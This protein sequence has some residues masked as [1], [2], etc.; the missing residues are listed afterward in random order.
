MQDYNND[1]RLPIP[2]LWEMLE[3][4][5]SL[6]HE[7]VR[8]VTVCNKRRVIIDV[9]ANDLY[10]SPRILEQYRF[11]LQVAEEVE[12][13]GCT[14]EDFHD[15]LA[16]PLLP[17]FQKLGTI[18]KKAETLDTFFNP[19]IFRYSLRAEGDSLVASEKEEDQ[20]EIPMFGSRIREEDYAKFPVFEPSQLHACAR[21]NGFGPP[22]IKPSKTQLPDGSVAF[23]KV[24][25]PGD[26]HSLETELRSYNKIQDAHL[27]PTL[28]ISRLLGIVRN[29]TLIV[30]ILLTYIDCK[31]KTLSCAAKSSSEASLRA[32]WL[33]QIE[34]TVACLHRSGIAW[35][36]AKPDN[37]MIDQNQD[38]WL[39]DFGD[40]YTEG[41]VPKELAGTIEGDRVG[42]EKIACFLE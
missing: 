28:R 14:I 7:D 1:P 38:A 16:E 11:F 8:L 30:G 23:L 2:P 34:E 33:T 31:N 10:L 24:M 13:D 18:E 17:I 26:R 27:D 6:E 41:W 15:W 42:L 35:G 21:E 25:H 39:I 12:L 36:D 20:D 40:S 5:F 22:S 19:E 4:T 32:K 9:E 3:F 37:V 29:E